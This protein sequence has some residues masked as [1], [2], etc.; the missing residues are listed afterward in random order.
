M[1][2]NAATQQDPR[3][4]PP[5]IK[6]LSVLES[7][8]GV[9][10]HDAQRLVNAALVLSVLPT[11]F[12]PRALHLAVSQLRAVQRRSQNDSEVLEQI[13]CHLEAIADG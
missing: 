4:T 7:P 9:M 13:I 2:S 5:M 8:R 11:M 10:E 12:D 6:R 1:S 3:P